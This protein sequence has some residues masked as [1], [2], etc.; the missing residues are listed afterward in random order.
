MLVL[1]LE[2]TLKEKSS[3]S[4]KCVFSIL[5]L[6]LLLKPQN[7]N[8]F[9]CSSRSHLLQESIL[10]PWRGCGLIFLQHSIIIDSS[11]CTVS[12]ALARHCTKQATNH[13]SFNHH[14]AL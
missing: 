1:V 11:E 13:I 3:A 5:T 10:T 14:Y 6:R 2:E 9:D 12:A 4:F 8:S 7:P